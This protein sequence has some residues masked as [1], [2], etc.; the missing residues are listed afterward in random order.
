[1]SIILFTQLNLSLEK[2]PHH[3]LKKLVIPFQITVTPLAALSRAETE[4]ENFLEAWLPGV[5]A[6]PS[7]SAL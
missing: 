4:C 1:M 2:I 5:V 6:R 7:P 3:E